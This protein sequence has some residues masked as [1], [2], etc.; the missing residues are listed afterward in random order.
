M[1]AS[2]GLCCRPAVFSH[3]LRLIALSF[4]QGKLWIVFRNVT[5]LFFLVFKHFVSLNCVIRRV[6]VVWTNE[7]I[8]K[9]VIGKWT[10]PKG[11]LNNVNPSSLWIK[12]TDALNSN[13]W[14]HYST[15][16]GQPFCPSSGV[17]GLHRLWYIL[18]SCD[19]PF[20]T[21]SRMAQVP[22]YSW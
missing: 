13:F 1:T 14:Y 10:V 6:Y 2:P 19:E 5:N 22:S 11:T 16:F 8:I 18:C 17:L 3:H 4:T 7:S 20:A 21:R 9:Y 12:P 15:C